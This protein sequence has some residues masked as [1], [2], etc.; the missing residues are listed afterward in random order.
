MIRKALLFGLGMLFPTSTINNFSQLF[1][2]FCWLYQL[3]ATA[4]NDATQVTH[5]QQL[6][7]HQHSPSTRNPDPSSNSQP[8]PPSPRPP[9]GRS[10][11]S[12]LS[13]HS[14]PQPLRA[15]AST[16]PPLTHRQS[17]L[18]LPALTCSVIP[19]PN[20]GSRTALTTPI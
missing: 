3:K 13:P 9:H 18:L 16:P 2:I 12:V 8:Q 20:G 17:F 7:V 5:P 1:L 6:N 15:P 11:F 19:S 4:I 10:S 14:A